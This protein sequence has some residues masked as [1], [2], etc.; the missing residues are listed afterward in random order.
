MKPHPV[1]GTQR[2]R[3]SR[4]SVQRHRRARFAGYARRL[5]LEA[6]EDRRL[7]AVVTVNTDNDVL[8]GATTSIANLIASPGLD[9]V[10]S[11][12][13]AIT[14]ANNTPNVGDPDEIRFNIGGGGPQTIQLQSALPAISD[15]VILDGTTQPGYAGAPIVELNGPA[16]STVLTL[17]ADDSTIRGLA[18][19]TSGT[20]VSLS[21]ADRNLVSGLDVSWAGA[22][23]SGLGIEIWNSSNN[24]LEHITARDRRTPIQIGIQYQQDDSSGNIFR[25]NDLSRAADWALDAQR[26]RGVGNQYVRNNLSGSANGAWFRGVAGLNLAADSFVLRDIPGTALALWGVTGSQISGLDVS[27]TGAGISGLGIEIWNSSNNTLD[28]ITASNRATGIYLN[29]STGTSI[30]SSSILSNATGVSVAGAST[31]IVLN[32]NDIAGNSV[33]GVSNT[34]ASNPPADVVNAGYN[35]WGAS[36]GPRGP[37]LTGSG[38]AIT[39]R[40]DAIPFLGGAPLTVTNTND[41]GA[42]SLRQAIQTANSQP[43]LS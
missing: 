15:A 10:I 8:D 5:R 41:S 9:G 2:L 25:D 16:G 32:Y 22:G 7:L 24:T 26:S 23:K 37:G 38:D 43:G 12:R 35:Y 39:D 3:A 14:A 36:N 33:H 30:R 31:G 1:R 11:L 28:H 42:G 40:V 17:A 18:I 6:L 21:G 13:E 19:R 34:A 29:S 27:W 20:A 4:K